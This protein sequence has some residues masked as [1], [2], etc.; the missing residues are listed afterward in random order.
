MF[1]DLF[2]FHYFYFIQCLVSDYYYYATFCFELYPT[3]FDFFDS[4]FIKENIKL[5][6][7]K[8]ASIHIN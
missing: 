6:K 1:L 5:K 2:T 7:I 4:Y 3:I 8:I